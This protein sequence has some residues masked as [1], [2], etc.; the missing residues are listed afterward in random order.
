VKIVYSSTIEQEQEIT[1]LVSCFFENLFPNFF[2]QEEISHYREIGVLQPK[3]Y[4]GTLKVAYQVMTC[5][6]VITSL[7][8]KKEHSHSFLMDRDA[9]LLLDHNI[10]LLNESGLYFPFNSGNFIRLESSRSDDPLLAYA[11]PA[12][13]YLL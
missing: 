9:E 10:K 7:L 12:N 1:K 11:V 3:N 5:L 8:E 13:E 6:Q 2:S 4:H